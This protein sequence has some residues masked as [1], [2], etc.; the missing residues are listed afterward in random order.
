[1]ETFFV[2]LFGTNDEKGYSRSLTGFVRE[3]D[4][5]KKDLK[6]FFYTLRFGT[7]LLETFYSFE[8]S[9]RPKNDSRSLIAKLCV[10]DRV[11]DELIFFFIFLGRKY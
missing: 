7:K 5:T 10:S 6:F 4:R 1:M 9:I 8:I 11:S 3:S 2:D